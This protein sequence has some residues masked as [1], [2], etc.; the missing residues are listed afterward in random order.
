MS[1]DFSWPSPLDDDPLARE[2]QS[3]P[4]VV[5]WALIFLLHLI[6]ERGFLDFESS[7][8]YACT[9]RRGIAAGSVSSRPNKT[10]RLQFSK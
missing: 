9:G 1:A 6:G 3:N 8:A 2:M 4:G 10:A 5:A 7:Q